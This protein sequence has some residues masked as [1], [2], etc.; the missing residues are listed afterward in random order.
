MDSNSTDGP[1]PVRDLL[2]QL[3][4]D[5][6]ADGEAVAP[7][8]VPTRIEEAPTEDREAEA[9]DDR[10]GS[11]TGTVFGLDGHEWVARVAGMG[12]Y[13]TGR[14][15]MALLQAVHFYRADEPDRPVREALLP[16]AQLQH[17]GPEELRAVFGRA[18]PI[19]VQ[20]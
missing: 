5:S 17:L 7:E 3:G 6:Q 13:G 15:G 16:A 4:Q 10:S 9:P 2:K 20:D 1:V 14:R 11:A 8:E 12:C 19:E 18:T